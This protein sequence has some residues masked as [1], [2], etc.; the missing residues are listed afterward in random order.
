PATPFQGLHLWRSAKGMCAGNAAIDSNN[1][2]IDIGGFPT[3]QNAATAAISFGLSG[4]RRG[5][6]L[7][8]FSATPFARAASKK[9]GCSLCFHQARS[10]GVNANVGASKFIGASL[11]E[12]VDTGLGRAIGGVA[13]VTPQSGDRRH[14]NQ[15]SASALLGHISAGML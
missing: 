15:G 7:P 8:I 6:F 2:A 1:L 5:L 9:V 13:T 3:C 14:K 12:A 10:N 11:S 4:R